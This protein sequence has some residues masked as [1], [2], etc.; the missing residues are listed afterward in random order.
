MNIKSILFSWFF[1]LTIYSPIFSGELLFIANEDQLD[2]F[3]GKTNIIMIASPGRSGSTLLTNLIYQQVPSCDIIKTH[4]LPPY[5]KYTGKILFIYSNPDKAAESALHMT[6]KDA[7]W[8]K[9]HFYHVKTS[10]QAWL[11]KIGDT[12][13]QSYKDNLLSYDALGVY[14]HLVE[15]LY[16]PV[17][18]SFEEAQILAIKYEDLWL[19]STIDSIN[20]FLGITNFTLPIKKERGYDL[21]DLTRKE[22]NFRRGY[23]LNTPDEPIYSAYDMAREIWKTAPSIQYFKLVKND[24]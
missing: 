16:K 2:R 14:Q 22:I 4:M 13:N 12:T 15:W 10:D 17:P 6:I 18:C 3:F 5:G 9:Q 11:N 19:S 1:I 24:N 20:Q 7:L 8:G 23:N 21:K